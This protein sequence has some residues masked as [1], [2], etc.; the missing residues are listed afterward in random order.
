M[1]TKKEVN[2]DV[3]PICGSQLV[4]AK[5]IKPTGHVGIM[6]FHAGNVPDGAEIL[7]DVK[8]SYKKHC[9]YRDTKRFHATEPEA[10]PAEP[11]PTILPD[12]SD[13]PTATEPNTSDVPTELAQD[14]PTVVI[15]TTSKF[16]AVGKVIE[17]LRN[18]GWSQNEIREVRT[19]FTTNGTDMNAIME[20]AKKYVN[21][22]EV[23]A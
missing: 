20:I 19:N 9:A 23:E 1:R 7:S 2:L 18:S 3:C 12:T 10:V 14:A 22:V 16:E 8:N 4:F 6:A 11:E 21:V 17:A 15:D 5:G 13:I